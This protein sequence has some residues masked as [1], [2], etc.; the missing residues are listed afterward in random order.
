MIRVGRYV[1][2]LIFAMLINKPFTD[3]GDGRDVGRQKV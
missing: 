1:R 2:K 3:R